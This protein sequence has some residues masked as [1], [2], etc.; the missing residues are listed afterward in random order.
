MIA[1]LFAFL[2][3]FVEID[4]G[5]YETGLSPMYF[6]IV[7]MTTLGYGDILP[8]SV[9]AQI[10]VVIQVLVGYIMLGGLLSI[11]ANKLARRAE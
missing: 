3:G 7:T 8:L 11:F 2:Y 10:L 6:S 9:P 5:D 4:Y 1:A